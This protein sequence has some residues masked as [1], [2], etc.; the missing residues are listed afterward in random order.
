MTSAKANDGWRCI[1]TAT[2]PDGAHLRLIRHGDA[3]TIAIGDNDLMS[4]CASGSEAALATMAYDRLGQRVDAE[5]LIGGYGMGY[6]LRAALE[7]LGRD[8][9][10]TVAELVPEIIDWARGPMRALTA[11]CLDD[12]RVQLV[13]QDVAT[14]IRAADAAYDAILLDVD[15]GPEG[16]SSWCND[17]L[18]SERGIAAAMHALKPDGLL[19]IWS[20]FDDP[21]FTARLE[22]AGF[23]VKLAKVGDGRRA[24]P[25]THILWFAQKPG[26]VA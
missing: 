13:Q 1:G 8:A 3:F 20:A 2:V 17:Y 14:L 22:E 5:W 11:G 16:L 9:C 26:S 4:T 21:R 7:V 19:A 6:T 10:V 23:A 15:N 18:Y 24:E 12:R 25:D